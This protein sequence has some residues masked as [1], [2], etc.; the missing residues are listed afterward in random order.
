MLY[1]ACHSPGSS[2]HVDM[3][4]R[5]QRGLTRMWL[6]FGN[7]TSPAPLRASLDAQLNYPLAVGSFFIHLYKFP[8]RTSVQ[9]CSAPKTNCIITSPRLRSIHMGRMPVRMNMVVVACVLMRTV[10]VHVADETARLSVNISAHADTHTAP[11]RECTLAKSCPML[12]KYN[13]WVL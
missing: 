2:R 7:I 9:F 6:S 13:V 1:E 4:P 5:E 11:N 10:H 3:S 12:G 8:A